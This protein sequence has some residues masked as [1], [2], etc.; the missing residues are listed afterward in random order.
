MGNNFE[1]REDNFLQQ[2]YFSHLRIK[3]EIVVYGMQSGMDKGSYELENIWPLR[4]HVYCNNLCDLSAT[5][6]GREW[7]NVC[8]CADISDRHSTQVNMPFAG[9]CPI[10]V[11]GEY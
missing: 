9:R 8:A 1:M 7:S 2:R 5:K 3:Q 4:M 6:F 10:R 11:A